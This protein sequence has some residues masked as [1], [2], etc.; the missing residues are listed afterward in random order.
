[1]AWIKENFERLEFSFVFVVEIKQL[2]L[3]FV[4]IFFLN[5]FLFTRGNLNIYMYVF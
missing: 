5:S 2:M 1:M 3:V 4:I